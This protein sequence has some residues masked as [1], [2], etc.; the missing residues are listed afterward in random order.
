MGNK[1]I[2]KASISLANMNYL[3]GTLTCTFNWSLNALGGA[4]YWG[5]GVN[6]QYGGSSVTNNTLNIIPQN[7]SRWSAKSGSVTISKTGV[8]STPQRFYFRLNSV[9]PTSGAPGLTGNY[10]V[11]VNLASKITQ[12]GNF[13]VEDEHWANYTKYFDSAYMDL[14][15]WAWKDGTDENTGVQIGGQGWSGYRGNYQSAEHTKFDSRQRAIVYKIAMPDTTVGT[16]VNFR[17]TLK[18]YTG[19]GGNY[20]GETSAVVKGTIKGNLK[21]KNNGTWKNCVPFFKYK[22]EW[23]PC[24]SAI[25]N[26]GSWKDSE[27]A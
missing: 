25:K 8:F 18:T 16:K 17:Y 22:N 4:S 14:Y 2:I 26:S 6:L 7:T 13:N 1:P 9:S 11:D 15:L 12:V 3:A 10:D 5:F 20:V 24:S 27:M 21:I 19:A 23:R